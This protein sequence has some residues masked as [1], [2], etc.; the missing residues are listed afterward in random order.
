[1]QNKKERLLFFYLLVN[2]FLKRILKRFMKVVSLN[3]LNIP[4]II[5]AFNMV[6]IKKKI[7]HIKSELIVNI[8]TK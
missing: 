4:K 5:I 3:I 1:M 2:Y 6:N 8:L 7:N